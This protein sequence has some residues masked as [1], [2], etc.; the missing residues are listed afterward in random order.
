MPHLAMCRP[1]GNVIPV[2]MVSSYS[3]NLA[4]RIPPAFSPG[5]SLML[6]AFVA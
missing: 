1:A 2:V 4:A 6:G 3:L 5:A